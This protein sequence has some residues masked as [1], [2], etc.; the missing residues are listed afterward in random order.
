MVNRIWKRPCSKNMFSF[1]HIIITLLRAYVL[2]VLFPWKH[3]KYF[4]VGSKCLSRFYLVRFQLFKDLE[5]IL[6]TAGGVTF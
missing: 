2:S 6:I 3:L 1:L 4:L 5:R